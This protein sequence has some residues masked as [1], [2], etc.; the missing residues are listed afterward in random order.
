MLAFSGAMPADRIQSRAGPFLC[1]SD[2]MSV[3]SALARAP[4][5]WVSLLLAGPSAGLWGGFLAFMVSVVPRYE[6]TFADF[7]VR[8]PAT[9]EFTINAARWCVKYWYVGALWLAMLAPVLAVLTILI[10]RARK[11]WL[12]ALWWLLLLGVPVIALASAWLCMEL[13][14]ASLL[15]D[16]K[17]ALK[18]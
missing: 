8:L 18:K 11:G 5:L 14:H 12:S 10:R 9:A 17:G 13:P 4:R 6:R 2:P 7:G 3:Q 1:G 15:R 16:L